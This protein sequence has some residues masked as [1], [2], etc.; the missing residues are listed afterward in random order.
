MSTNTV[1]LSL[2]LLA[3]AS[4]FAADTAYQTL[5]KQGLHVEGFVPH[6]IIVNNNQTKIIR[7]MNITLSPMV[8]KKLA[9]RAS[10]IIQNPYHVG[11]MNANDMPSMI[12]V[13][14]NGEPVLDQGQWGTCATFS[15]SA[16]VNAMLSLSGDSETSQLCNLAVGRTLGNGADGGWDG[17]FGYVVLGQIAQYGFV[18]KQYQHTHGCGGL[19]KYPV[20]SDDSGSAMPLAKFSANSSKTFTNNDWTPILSYDGTFAPVDSAA[21]TQALND[22]KKALNKGNRVVFGSLIDGNVGE[23]GATGTYN[24]IDNDTWVMTSAIQQDFQNDNPMEGHEIIIDGYDDNACATYIDNSKSVKQC[25]LLRIRNSWGASA[26]D[27]GDYYM[28]YD[29]FKGMVIEAY[30]IGKNVKN[31]FQSSVN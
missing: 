4:T 24:G 14:M 7:L 15:S 25:G 31:K 28:S 18:N 22:V 27:Q 30:A 11:M 23:V 8:A 16:A 19:K 3:S 2:A 13:G 21:A 1:V 6:Q 20:D 10:D 5:L 29:H 17:S 9:G 12:R 26:G